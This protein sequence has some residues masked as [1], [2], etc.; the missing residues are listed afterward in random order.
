MGV[1]QS[2][3][4]F[5]LVEALIELNDKAK[6]GVLQDDEPLAY[7]VD[8]TIEVL[9]DRIGEF[10]VGFLEILAAGVNGFMGFLGNQL[11]FSS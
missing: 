7:G 6:P 5:L 2:D 4:F 1:E 9:L 11:I 8:L 10:V 3:G